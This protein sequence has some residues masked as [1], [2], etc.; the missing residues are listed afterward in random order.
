MRLR[1]V[2]IAAGVVIGLPVIGL[3]VFVATFDANA[4]KPRII[5]A[6]KEATGRELSLNG[7][8][9]LK[10][11]LTP[12][13]RVED[14][15]FANAP[16]GS[17]PQMATLEALEVEVAVLPLLSG[18]VQINRIVLV[19]PDILLETDAEGRGNWEIAA[20]AAP[21]APPQAAPQGQAPAPA[22]PPQAGVGRDIGIKAISITD[23]TV[24]F[25]D[26]KTGETI[27][28]GLPRFSARADSRESPLTLDLEA[29]LN[30]NA[31]TLTG[32]LGP[33]SR[34]LG[35]E[36]TSPWPVDLTA[37]AAG[38]R[39]AIKG[40]VAEPKTGKGY[41]LAV[42]ASV[43]D[44]SRL[45]PFLP[46]V[47]LPPA[48]AI[49]LSVQAA[50]RGRRL[51]EISALTV[52][53]GESDLNAYL[54]G[55]RLARLEVSA[56]DT[57]S[58]VR[59]S[60]AAT[61][62]GAPVGAEGTLG[63]LGAFLPGASGQP[64]PVDLR[65]TAATAQATAKGT[66]ARPATPA[67]IDIALAATVPDIAALSPLA[68]GAALPAIKDV[69][70]SARA[71]DRRGG[72]GGALRDIALK[73]GPSDL[74]GN[75]ELEIGARPKL[76]ATLASERFDLDQLMAATGGGAAPAGTPATP[77]PPA[78]PPAPRTAQARL[79][80][81]TPIPFAALRATDA[82][83]KLTVD[84]L[85]FGGAP[86]RA[87]EATVA[88]DRGKLS[89]APFK[90]T[91]PGAPVSGSLTV[92][93]SRDVAPVAVK[94]SAPAIDLRALLAAYGGGY[95]V[96]GTLELDVDLRGAGATPA[97][98][99]GSLDGHLGLAG[100]NLDIDNRLLDLVAGEV[101]RAMVPGAPRDGSNNVRCLAFRFD[102]TAG[103]AQANAFLFDSALAKVAGTGSVL[104]GPEQLQLRAVPTLKF[105]GGG[106]GVPVLIG[107]TFLAPS[108]RVDPAGAVGALAG[109]A[110][111]A[112]AGATAG[113]AA[114]PLGAIVGGVIGAARPG[115]QRT[116]DDCPGQLA[117]ARG[118]KAGAAPE[119]EAAPAEAPA[120]APAQQQQ[121]Q[122]QQR[123]ANP[124]QQLLPR[125]GR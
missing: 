21:A 91:A 125:L 71:Q 76:T 23:G 26:G 49:E 47:E 46:N 110:S 70:F 11:G 95:R 81:D 124:L 18:R 19:R 24:A 14:V 68:G 31:F 22:A 5:A 73:L 13:L 29:A 84:E 4:Y 99:A 82:A 74:S 44:L 9:G 59:L 114:G 28:L 75:A 100:V 77:A 86:Y 112:T 79:I 85:V 117:I 106:F 37:T 53:A 39:V 7:D 43:P 107:G 1:T 50:D 54:P 58:P 10:L 62:N 102:S 38:A 32:T 8:I 3:G 12:A 120:Q 122:Q 6:A 33:V 88:L 55:L 41:D 57:R 61:L 51:P 92:D 69:T 94:L 113:A 123:P 98:I 65:V 40:S 80:P 97:A 101:W 56:P 115:A 17:R 16:W 15:A 27:T 83:L 52:K 60:L 34:L 72:S 87:V 66:I 67:G 20:P 93:A 109:I 104:L 121:Q 111:G 105:G 42:Q 90:A 116:G 108:V 63:P 89:V 2:L 35:A 25:R 48:R 45:A 103:T 36:G 119:P 30:G 96:G 64:W 118:G 78:P